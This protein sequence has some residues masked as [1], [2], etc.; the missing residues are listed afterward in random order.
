MKLRLALAAVLLLG[1]GAGAWLVWQ[2]GLEPVPLAD[3]RKLYVPAVPEFQE[4]LA[5]VVVLLPAGAG[6]EALLV[7][8]SDLPLLEKGPNGLAG[9]LIAEAAVSRHG[10]RWRLTCGRAGGCRTGPP[11]MPPACWRPSR[12]G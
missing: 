3:A 10:R 9:L 6:V 4:D 12:P 1:L 11:W 8:Q 5:K 2:N 7:T